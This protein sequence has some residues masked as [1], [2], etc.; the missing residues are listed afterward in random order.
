LAAQDIRP[1]LR[2]VIRMSNRGLGERMSQLLNNC[3]TLSAAAIAAPAFVTAALGEAATAPMTVAA[4][5]IVAIRLRNGGRPNSVVA[6][7]AVMGPSGSEPEVLPPDDNQRAD[8]FLVP[9][10]PSPPHPRRHKQSRVR[11]IPIL[12]GH[13]LRAVLAAFLVVLLAGTAVLS[14]ARGI[15]LGQAAYTALI[16]ELS[17]SADSNAVGVAKIV[18]VFLTLVSVVIIPTL[19]AA[20][21]DSLVQTRLRLQA[22]GLV[23]PTSNHVVV[24][25]L[26]N[27]GT[28]I[29]RALHEQGVE[30][31][32]I[33]RESQARG[34]QVARDL[35]IPFILGDASRSETLTA[36]SVATARALV[37]VSSDDVT[38][39]ETALLARQAKPDLRV[40][41]RLFDAEFADRVNRAFGID[42]SRS[43]S[44]LAAPAFAAAMI[45]RQVLATIPVRRHVLLIAE[46]PVGANS[47]LELQPVSAINRTHEVRLLAIRSGDGQVLWRPSGGRPIRGS[48]TLVVVTTRRGLTRLLEDTATPAEIDVTTPYRLLEPWDIPRTRPAFADESGDHPPSPPSDAGSANPE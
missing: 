13:R 19:T 6:P 34:I 11:L 12:F 3:V 17:G 29:I 22:G 45:G 23:E 15:S 36:A 39:L 44:Y 32:A 33:E 4:R 37:V 2:I 16:T 30:V 14:W 1:D 46:L 20:V 47:P 48:D 26:G 9:A 28:R 42:I 41:V 43:V 25:G 7:L 35:G 27:V 40:V 18:M 21:V 10:K 31:V 8:F 24:V 5:T 38:N